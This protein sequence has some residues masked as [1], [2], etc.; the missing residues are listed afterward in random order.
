M[1]NKYFTLKQI[2]PNIF[3]LNFNNAYDLGMMFLRYQEFYESPSKKIRGKSMSI[4]R[5]MEWYARYSKKNIFTYPEDFA[6][7]NFPGENILKVFE[8]GI[9]DYNFYDLLMKNVY[10]H[11]ASYSNKFYIVATIGKKSN[12]PKWWK[13]K[14]QDI[15]KHEVAHALFY[16]NKEY[17]KEMVS[18]INNLPK[19]Y[20]TKIK[21][22]LKKLGYAKTVYT[23]EMQAYLSCG[24]HT[25][26]G[27]IPKEITSA[28]SKT[29]KKYCKI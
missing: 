22:A 1:R 12:F 20:K 19:R 13:D 3:L 29:Y 15:I 7:D 5:L 14:P 21:I 6:G 10:E 8:A 18:L 26:F 27:K 2:L 28:F 25:S 9:P 4:L 23:D 17:K 11:C 24:I 16:L